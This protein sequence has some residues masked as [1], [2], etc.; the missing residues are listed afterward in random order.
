M[1][2]NIFNKDYT[3]PFLISALQFS[4][5]QKMK[6]VTV[7]QMIALEKQADASGLSYAQMMQNA[8]IGLAKI[9]HE[10]GQQKNWKKVIGLVGAGNNGGDT[11]VALTWLA[12]NGW[13]TSAYLTKTNNNELIKKY[14]DVGGKIIQF[15]NIESYVNESDVVLDGVLGTGIKLPLKKEASEVLEKVKNINPKFVVAVDCPSG[16]DCDSGE[17]ANE[18]IPANLTVTMAAIKQGLLK[19]PAFEKIGDLQLVEIG[20][21]DEMLNEIKVDVADDEM[22]SALLPKRTLASHKGTFGTAFVIAGS[23]S[24]TGAALLAGTAAYRIGAGLVTMAVP[25]NLHSALAGHLPEAT[26]VLLPHEN[27]FI[28]ESASDVLLNNLSGATSIL[29]G[30]GL[31]NKETTKQFV[32]KLLPSIKIPM[33]IDADGLRHLINSPLLRGEGLGVRSILTPHLGEMS[34]L[35]GLSKEEIQSNR[36]EVAKKYAKQWNCVV[37]LKGAF[38]IIAS[39]DERMT[40]IPIATS[41][42]ARAGTGDVL[43]GLITGLLAQGLNPYDAAV[44]GAYIHGKAGLLAAERLGTTASV[45]ASDVVNTVS[46]VISKLEK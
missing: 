43:A 46:E 8:G 34:A 39:P 37:V 23:I 24:Y 28:S 36:E 6:L 38:T 44:A 33:V 12:E 35:T 16:V 30:S 21:S 45:L 9:V 25:E 27:G 14:I 7:S 5:P 13:E 20:L 41:A 11:L 18:T 31:G 15:E 42:L 22:I 29:I 19:L 4:N 17:C 10:M 2:Y 40:I 1:L 32:E 3:T 26:W